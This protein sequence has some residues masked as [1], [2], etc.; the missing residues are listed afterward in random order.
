MRATYSAHLILLALI[1]LTTLGEEYK[2]CSSSLCSSLYR[3]KINLKLY[4][5]SETLFLLRRFMTIFLWILFGSYNGK[6]LCKVF[7]VKNMH[8]RHRKKATLQG[9]HLEMTQYSI[10]I[11]QSDILPRSPDLMIRNNIMLSISIKCEG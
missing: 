8:M 7:R 1:T 9:M 10:C 2:P 3:H 11:I 6:E 5:D 4:H